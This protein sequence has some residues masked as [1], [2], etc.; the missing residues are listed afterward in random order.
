M[1]IITVVGPAVG[2]EEKRKL[3]KGLT[4]TASAV[5]GL[6]EDAIIVLIQENPPENVSRGGVLIVDR[7]K[8]G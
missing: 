5:Y 4:D 7:I 6:P 8:E 3:A 2:I 1:P